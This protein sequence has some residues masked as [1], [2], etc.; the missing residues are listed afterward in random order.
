MGEL[1]RKIAVDIVQIALGLIAIAFIVLA[2]AWRLLLG[3]IK[4]FR[5]ENNEGLRIG[6]KF[7]LIFTLSWQLVHFAM[8]VTGT[9]SEDNAQIVWKVIVYSAGVV[10]LSVILYIVF[11]GIIHR[12]RGSNDERF[13][14]DEPAIIF[15]PLILFFAVSSGV[16]FSGCVIWSAIAILSSLSAGVGIT[17]GDFRPQNLQLA[18]W[19]ISNASSQLV[20][21][22]ATLVIPVFASFLTSLRKTVPSP[23]DV[24]ED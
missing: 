22:F 10:Y 17:T 11:S 3:N 23:T 16:M 8:A 9:Y 24:S 15:A 21:G 18:G 6:V 12:I 1:E 13:K 5:P 14:V 4:Q 19:L 20:Y 7:A 2:L